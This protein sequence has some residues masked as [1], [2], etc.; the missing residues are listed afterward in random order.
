MYSRTLQNNFTNQAVETSLNM[1]TTGIKFKKEQ[2]RN[3]TYEKKLKLLK[4]DLLN[5]PYHIFK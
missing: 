1:V 3:I 2:E 4:H 5:G